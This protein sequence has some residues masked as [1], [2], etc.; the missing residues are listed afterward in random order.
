MKPTLGTNDAGASEPRSR[1]A[2]AFMAS[3]AR[4]LQDDADDAS[5]DGQDAGQKRIRWLRGCQL[6]PKPGSAVLFLDT[7]CV[8]GDGGVLDIESMLNLQ[9]VQL[10]PCSKGRGLGFGD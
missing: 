5:H 2:A 4:G 1:G 7:D 6:R 3:L 8:M 10:C 9:K